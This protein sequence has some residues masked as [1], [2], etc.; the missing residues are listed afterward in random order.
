[1]RP[2]GNPSFPGAP[3]YGSFLSVDI[4]WPWL[5]R[6]AEFILTA[7]FQKRISVSRK[8]CG[9]FTKF[10]NHTRIVENCV[11]VQVRPEHLEKRSPGAERAAAVCRPID[12]T[13]K[14]PAKPRPKHGPAH[15]ARPRKGIRQFEI[16]LR[17]RSGR[18]VVDTVHGRT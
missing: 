3:R 4:G 5:R 10:R 16:G 15:A 18:Q 8:F 17:A 2:G 1:M 12:R 6:I 9:H 13:G 14:G 11:P 7:E